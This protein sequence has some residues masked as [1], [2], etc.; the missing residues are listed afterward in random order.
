MITQSSWLLI[1]KVTNFLLCYK[2]NVH[3]I[4]EIRNMNQLSLY[5]LNLEF[6]IQLKRKWEAGRIWGIVLPA[7]LLSD[8]YQFP[9]SRTF[10]TTA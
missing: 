4:I 7:S 10:L 2:S 3:E 5:E 9:S 1:N 6:L 8:K